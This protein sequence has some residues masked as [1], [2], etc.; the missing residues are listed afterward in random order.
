MK[1]LGL[2]SLVLALATTL[3]A[4]ARV[5]PAG[6][7]GATAASEDAASGSTRI[8]LSGHVPA[9]VRNGSARKIGPV[10]PNETI[11]I[12]ISSR[13]R[14]EATLQ[15]FIDDVSNPASPTYGN[16]L[17]P[18]EFTARFGATDTQRD[19]VERFLARQGLHVTQIFNNG[20]LITAEG[21]IAVVSTA[22][23]V[24]LNRYQGA[25]RSTFRAPSSEPSLPPDVANI[26]SY[27][28]G[29]DSLPVVRTP[30]APQSS[31][32]AYTPA[33]LANAYDAA[34]LLGS[35]FN[36]SGEKVASVQFATYDRADI[37]S[38]NQSYVG[39]N[40]TLADVKICGGASSDSFGDVETTLDIELQ[41]AAAPGANMIIEYNAPLTSMACADAMIQQIATE[42]RATTIS[43]SW[44]ICEPYTPSASNA[45]PAQHNAFLQMASQG[46]SFFAA[47]GDSGSLDCFAA[48]GGSQNGN[49]VDYPAS[50]DHVTG[51]GGTTLTTSNGN[52]V[53]ETTWNQGSCSPAG[54][55]ASGGGLSQFF[56]R[57]SWQVGPGTNNSFSNG[58]REVPDVSLDADPNTGY[59]F[60][61]QGSA[62]VIGGTSAGAPTW[63]GYAAIYN[64]YA[65]TH[66]KPRLGFANPALY[67][68]ANSASRGVVFHDVTVGT[69]ITY[70]ATV[71]YDLATGWG[72]PNVEKLVAA[73]ANA[74][75]SNTAT[76]IP[77]ATQT[78]P[79]TRTPTPTPSPT[80]TYEGTGPRSPTGT[81]T[82][83]DAPTETPTNTPL[84]TVQWVC[85]P[86]PTA[87][88]ATIS[89]VP[90]IYQTYLPNVSNRMTGC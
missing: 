81:P 60:V 25:D 66:G 20:T 32:T 88:S 28:A 17:S 45:D 54:C 69:N 79:P 13:L 15:S 73:L 56:L 64:Q 86:A 83:T 63:A 4:L 59:V 21:S 90:G 85:T 31:F 78:Q 68:V 70:P 1:R 34:N 75:P 52:Y 80:E 24:A 6:T 82:A 62:Y 47:S 33:Q 35:G 42:N 77:T 22:F 27:I 61:Y 37:T 48:G 51:V 50:D 43:T 8:R 72:S 41:M 14:D 10:D 58:K 36:G 57:P 9:P 74:A 76:P 18:S 2:V 30:R 26:V 19:T 55:G 87:S 12:G 65:R 29:L 38:F 71:A 67:G 40:A 7:T 89:P 23:G 16:Y 5:T 84:P 3:L 44:G 53:S 39:S 49:F 11:V 46:Q